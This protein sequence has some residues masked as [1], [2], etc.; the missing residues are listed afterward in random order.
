[1]L[2]QFWFGGFL[3]AGSLIAVFTESRAALIGVVLGV[4]IMI[5]GLVTRARIKKEELQSP[6]K[7]LD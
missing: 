3:T 1:M 2:Y 5:G 6:M 4:L 7:S